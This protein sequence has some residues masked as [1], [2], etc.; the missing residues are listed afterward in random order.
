MKCK[1]FNNVVYVLII[2]LPIMTWLEEVV[3][4]FSLIK[5]GYGL[6]SPVS[7]ILVNFFSFIC[8][9]KIPTTAGLQPYNFYCGPSA[10]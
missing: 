5:V 4:V 6:K 3:F 9:A 7:A 1:L 8:I 10:L 2:S